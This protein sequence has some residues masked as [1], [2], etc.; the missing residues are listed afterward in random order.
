MA[1]DVWAMPPGSLDRALN[2]SET[3]RATACFHVNALGRCGTVLDSG[4]GTGNVALRLL[5]RGKTVHAVDTNPDALEILEK[6]CAAYKKF[7]RVYNT[8]AEK[9]PFR[10]REFDGITSMFVANFVSDFEKYLSEHHRVLRENGFLAL[11]SAPGRNCLT[12]EGM[13][14]LLEKTGFGQVWVFQG[15]CFSLLARK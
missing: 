6:K 14:R 3:Y 12:P 7:L 2:S 13:K 9:L 10:D 4:C 15:R 8:S 5:R 1:A 11:S